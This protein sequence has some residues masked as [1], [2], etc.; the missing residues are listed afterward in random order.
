MA[1]QSLFQ[2]RLLLLLLLL[3]LILSG[4][5]QVTTPAAKVAQITKVLKGSEV[6][7]E[8]IGEVLHGVELRELCYLIV[9]L[10]FFDYC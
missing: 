2:L 10:D 3:L 9:E 6:L 8:Y 4:I 1:Q 5:I 7:A